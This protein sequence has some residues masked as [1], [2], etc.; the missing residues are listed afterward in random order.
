VT[1]AALTSEQQRLCDQMIHLVKGFAEKAARRGTAVN[2][3]ELESA[4]YEG[5]TLAAAHY[6]PSKGSFEAFAFSYVRNAMASDVR[7][8]V[9]WRIRAEP[10]ARTLIP[11]DDGKEEEEDDPLDPGKT[12]EELM[13][14]SVQADRVDAITELRLRVGSYWSAMLLHESLGDHEEDHLTRRAMAHG[15]EV[16]N[17]TVKTLSPRHQTYFRRF[18]RQERP[19]AE[20]A[21]ELNKS[22]KTIQRL[23]VE[24]K[25]ALDA[26]LRAAKLL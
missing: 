11:Q 15:L 13:A 2:L 1:A 7:K 14:R 21:L 20:I 4:G 25:A 22:V 8:T 18:Y 12:L 17:A 23:G 5:L 19:L 6:D 24:V 3:D 10:L 26:A 9:R 16:I